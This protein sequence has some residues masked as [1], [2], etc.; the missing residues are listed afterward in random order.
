MNDLRDERKLGY[1]YS[2]LIKPRVAPA[3]Q[4][5]FPIAMTA[6]HA[7][8]GATAMKRVQ[9][10]TPD[11]L[12]IRDIKNLDSFPANTRRYGIF[13]ANPPAGTDATK[14]PAFLGMVSRVLSSSHV[15]AEVLSAAIEVTGKIPASA[16]KGLDLFI[17]PL[18]A[19][20]KTTAAAIPLVAEAITVIS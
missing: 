17:A 20:R 19:D 11:F 6:N 4:Q 14:S 7:V 13:D 9:A 1:Q 2:S 5:A 12:H 16:T 3:E 10:P 15:H 8:V 18:S